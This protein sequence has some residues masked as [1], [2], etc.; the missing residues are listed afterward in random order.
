MYHAE[1]KKFELFLLT[2][3]TA[4]QSS[5]SFLDKVTFFGQYKETF[6]F[7]SQAWSPKSSIPNLDNTS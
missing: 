2:H 4:V 7:L 5:F 6:E 3:S 1:I